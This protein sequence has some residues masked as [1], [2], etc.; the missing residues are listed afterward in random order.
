[1]KQDDNLREVSP[2]SV[3]PK[4]NTTNKDAHDASSDLEDIL[5]S[6]DEELVTI[7]NT[8]KETEET[9]ANTSTNDTT[10]HKAA[11]DSS[12]AATVTKEALTK[13]GAN[14]ETTPMNMTNTKIAPNAMINDE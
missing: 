4:W 3:H 10:A 1:M 12:E 2:S 11:E 9:P 8:A 13:E 5:R 14:G 6:N 7:N